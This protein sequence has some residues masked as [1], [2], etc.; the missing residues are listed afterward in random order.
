MMKKILMMVLTL[1][2]VG[3]AGRTAEDRVRA[4]TYCKQH[5]MSVT[6]LNSINAPMGR[7]TDFGCYKDGDPGWVYTTV[8]ESIY[9]QNQ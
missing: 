7:V 5:D 8:P 4:E 1:S 3:C 2:L 9:R 6:T